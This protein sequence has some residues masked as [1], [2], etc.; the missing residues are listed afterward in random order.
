MTGSEFQLGENEFIQLQ[1]LLKFTGLCDSGGEAKTVITG[2][3][4]TVDGEVET[5]RGKK[6][7]AGQRVSYRGS[8]VDVVE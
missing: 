1:S 2:G 7:R 6:I 8:T 5:Q 3:E 4:V